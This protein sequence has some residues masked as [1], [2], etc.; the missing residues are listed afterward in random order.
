M[1]MLIDA[2]DASET[3]CVRLELPLCVTFIKKY[4]GWNFTSGN[5]LFTT[6]TK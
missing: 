3:Q 2:C 4:E 5:Y 1:A 6:D